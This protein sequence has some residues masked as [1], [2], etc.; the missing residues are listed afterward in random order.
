[1]PLADRLYITHVAAAPE[2]D[3]WFPKIDPADWQVIEEPEVPP[4]DRDS[5]GFRVKVY[6]RHRPPER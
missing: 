3:T 4:S 1:M 6:A 5:A 2:G